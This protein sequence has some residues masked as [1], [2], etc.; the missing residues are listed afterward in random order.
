MA[1]M[2]IIHVDRD[3]RVPVGEALRLCSELSASGKSTGFLYFPDENHWILRPG[4]INVGTRQSLPLRRVRAR[5]RVATPRPELTSQLRLAACP[6]SVPFEG[7]SWP[8][9]AS[10]HT[11]TAVVTRY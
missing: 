4:D 2:L 7:R 8:S 10:G 6:P 11:G 9:S 1:P 5:R 3:Y